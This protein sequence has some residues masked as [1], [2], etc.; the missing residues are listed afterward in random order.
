MMIGRSQAIDE[1]VKIYKQLAVFNI[2][3]DF[4]HQKFENISAKMDPGTTE[5]D[6]EF[7][8][9]DTTYHTAKHLNEKYKAAKNMVVFILK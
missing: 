4:V 6:K 1:E 3:D 7:L 2:I 9:I 5:I 8:I